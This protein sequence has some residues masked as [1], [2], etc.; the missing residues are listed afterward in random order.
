MTT[1]GTTTFTPSLGDFTIA[2]Y[3]RCGL[4]RTELVSQHM[5]DAR[6][7]ANMLTSEWTA[8]GVNLWAVDSQVITLVGG[9]SIYSIP[10]DT[11]FILDTY[12][13]NT[14]T[15]T[16]TIILPISRSDYAAIPNKTYLGTPTTYWFDRILSETMTLWPVPSA[17]STWTLTYWRAR[18]IQ[19]STLSNGTAPEVPYRFYD[20]FVWAL[21]AR[22]AFIYAPDRAPALVQRAQQAWMIAISSDT[23]NVPVTIRP[24]LRGYFR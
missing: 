1:S 9:Q 7:E 24:A 13:T 21:A 8:S 22:L 18:R 17:S 5:A 15:T 14:S 20:A 10:A 23:E 2:A 11:V 12:I 6:F 4:K 3:A 19:D 16:D